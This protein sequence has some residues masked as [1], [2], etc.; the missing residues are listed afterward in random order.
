MNVAA[1]GTCSAAAKRA[2]L[3]CGPTPQ[4][5]VAGQQDRA[6]PAAATSRAAWAIAS[7]VG[8]GKYVRPGRQRAGPRRRTRDGI[9]RE[10]S[11]SSMWVGPGFSSVRDAER[12]A[13]DLG[14]G[15]DA[16]DTRGSTW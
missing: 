11:G 7:S 5:A 12:L 15:V 6:G 4:D 1:T 14:D 16:L 9:A 10:F 8:S 2:Q 3:R 13:H